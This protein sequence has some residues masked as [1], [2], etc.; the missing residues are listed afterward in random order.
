MKQIPDD[1]YQRVKQLGINVKEQLKSQGI[2]VPSK[3]EDGTT[4]IGHYTIKKFKNGFYSILNSKNETVV[5][6]INLPQTAAIVANRLALG[7]NIDDDVLTVDRQYGHALFEEE[8]HKT[9]ADRNLRSNN[10]DRAEI[11][12]TKFYISKHKKEQYK[13]TIVM[14]FNKLI[15]FR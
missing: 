6:S 11:L 5:E 4:R 3:N 15:R 9:M 1:I 13:N 7:K 12:Y 10:T 8:L 14:G 2:V